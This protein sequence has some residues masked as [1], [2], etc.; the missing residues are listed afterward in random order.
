MVLVGF[1]VSAVSWHV[2]SLPVLF[3]NATAGA[4]AAVLFVL[5][6]ED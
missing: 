3:G 1:D 6:L 2:C 4:G 5:C